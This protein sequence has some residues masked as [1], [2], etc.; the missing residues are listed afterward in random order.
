MLTPLPSHGAIINFKLNWYKLNWHKLKQCYIL[1]QLVKS[2]PLLAD[3]TFQG[4]CNV[5]L[6]IESG[7]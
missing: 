1:F 5:S 3:K 6:S 7:L 2:R 4:R